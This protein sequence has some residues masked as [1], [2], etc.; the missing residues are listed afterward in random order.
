[1][2]PLTRSRRFRAFPPSRRTHRR[3]G[4]RASL[5]AV[6][7]LGLVLAWV[8]P[9]AGA[10]AHRAPNA[11]ALRDALRGHAFRTIDGAPLSLRSLE[12][13][14][15]VLNFWASW[16][17]PCRRELPSLDA[18]NT[19]LAAQGG[20]VLAISIDRDAEK[21]RRFAKTY[22]L[23][24]PIVHD[25][26]EGVVR[27]LDLEH[28]PFTVVLDRSG[29]VAYTASGSDDAA[30]TALRAVTRRLVAAKPLV[31]QTVEGATR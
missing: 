31:S 12:G 3:A 17:Q 1:M 19:Q 26:P 13:Q 14:V 25:G 10:S 8:S 30:L 15:V 2:T 7:A 20:R 9:T 23:S 24:L 28:V 16:C 4:G 6:S 11:A 5:L 27:K 21:A 29:E 18:L 22:R